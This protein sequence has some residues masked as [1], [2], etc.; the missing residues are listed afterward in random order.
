MPEGSVTLIKW[1]NVPGTRRRRVLAALLLLAY[2]KRGVYVSRGGS[3]LSPQ[4]LAHAADPKLR[5]LVAEFLEL[6]VPDPRCVFEA[7]PVRYG[8][9][10]DGGYRLLDLPV[11]GV[12]SV[13]IGDNDSFDLEWAFRGVNVLQVDNAQ[14]MAPSSH[15]QMRFVRATVGVEPGELDLD[16]LLELHETTFGRI[17]GNTHMVLKLDVEGAEWPLLSRCDSLRQWDQL[18]VEF[19]HLERLAEP[20][21]SETILRS[22]RQIAETHAPVAIHGNACCGFVT[23]GGIPVPRVLE[24]SFAHRRYLKQPVTKPRQSDWLR[25]EY[26]ESTSNV[27]GASDL[28]LWGAWPLWP[29]ET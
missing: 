13:G 14:D 10:G 18:I 2:G 15:D 11:D 28:W 9:L 16:D 23:L 24:V 29:A 17:S 1:L 8:S 25:P 4:D 3:I 22:A 26:V 20:A 12:V 7:S 27:P 19:H 21:E 6:V 5:R